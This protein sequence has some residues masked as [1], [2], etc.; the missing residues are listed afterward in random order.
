[1]ADGEGRAVKK[2]GGKQEIGKGKPGPGR[3]KGVPNKT[4]AM[5]KDAVLE[6]AAKAGGK[7][8]LVGYLQTQANTNPTAFMSLLGK[9]M[10]LQ[11]QGTGENGAFVNEII[12]R[13]VPA[14][15]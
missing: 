15:R 13:G 2:T 4:T 10:P 3:P 1:M 14:N 6:A 7:A 8:G 5:L 9:A 12:I 11:V